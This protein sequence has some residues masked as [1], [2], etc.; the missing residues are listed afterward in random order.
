MTERKFK[1]KLDF[2]YKSLAIYLLTLVVYI[3]VKGKFF[4]ERFEVMFRDPI[5]YIISLFILYFTVLLIANALW[6]RTI[7]FTGK[8]IVIS[9]R[10]GKRS[11]GIDEITGVRFTRKRRKTDEDMSSARFVKLKL[12]N[13]RRIL[14]IKMNDFENEK[15]LESEFKN[16]SRKLSSNL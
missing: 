2:Y 8:E 1:Y 5:I 4:Q 16:I 15:Q 9:N 7:E 10:F 6:A 14:R 13:R 11:I 12:K 3:L